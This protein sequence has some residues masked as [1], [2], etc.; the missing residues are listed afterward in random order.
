MGF[1]KTTYLMFGIKLNEKQSEFTQK[2]WS[3]EKLNLIKYIEGRP[4]VQGW[5][6]IFDVMCCKDHYFG[7]VMETMNGCDT[8]AYR[9]IGE[10][11]KSCEEFKKVFKEKFD[12][13]FS[14]KVELEDMEPQLMLINHFY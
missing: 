13:C 9:V 11:L 1:E 14:N 6:L 5:T 3:N 8:T 12:D 4:E 10:P 7:K 2:N